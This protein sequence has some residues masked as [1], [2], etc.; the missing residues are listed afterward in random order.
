MTVVRS[1]GAMCV[2][3]AAIPVTV[4]CASTPESPAQVEADAA[5]ANRVSVAL[6]DDPF[7]FFRHMEVSVEHG[8]VHLNGLVWTGD[9]IIRAQQ[10]ARAVPG[11]TGVVDRLEL[12]RPARTGGAG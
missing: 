11:V 9:A 8:V 6:N 5:I 1:A 10:I 7:F 4:A 2:V 12:E 3:L